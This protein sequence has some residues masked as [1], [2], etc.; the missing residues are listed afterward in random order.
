MRGK[1]RENTTTNRKQN[2]ILAC[3]YTIHRTTSPKINKLIVA[4]ENQCVA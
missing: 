1:E 2:T 4:H 3:K